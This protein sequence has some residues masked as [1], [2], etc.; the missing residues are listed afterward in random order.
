[1]LDFLEPWLVQPRAAVT[2]PLY[3]RVMLVSPF[4]RTE[5]SSRLSKISPTLDPITGIRFGSVRIRR[6]SS[7]RQRR[8]LSLAQFGCRFLQT[9][10]IHPPGRLGF[11]CSS[12]LH[13]AYVIELTSDRIPALIQTAQSGSYLPDSID[14]RGR[15]NQERCFLRRSSS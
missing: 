10:H 8:L 3:N 13:R 9:A 1:M 4:D 12:S 6:C 5:F 11:A 7:A 2:I 14:R 15:G